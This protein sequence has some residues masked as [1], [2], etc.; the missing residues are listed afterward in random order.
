MIN[1]FECY[2]QFEHNITVEIVLDSISVY[3]GTRA[4]TML[5]E[6]PRFILP[7][8]NTHRRFSKNSASSRALSFDKVL[9][10]LKAKYYMPQLW[11]ADHQGMQTSV[12][13]SERQHSIANAIWK[14]S[15]YSAIA[16]AYLL[17]KVGVSKQYVNR[18]IEPYAY[19]K[20]LVT[21]TEWQNFFNQRD[22]YHAQY[23]IQVLARRMRQALQQSIPTTLEKGQWHLPFIA[24]ALL[25]LPLEERLLVSAARCARTSYGRN[26]GY[27]VKKDMDLSINTLLGSPP[28]MSPFEHQLCANYAEDESTSN[29]D[30][31]MQQRFIIDQ[32]VKRYGK[33]TLDK[34]LEY[35][36]YYN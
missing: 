10:K 31:W 21:S 18:I 6:F 3:S 20:V 24:G 13:V 25:E 34:Y 17:N 33:F 1:F 30:G 32:L 23:E 28:H 4:T 15:M 36:S 27:S 8:F 35:V 16:H 19:V 14:S 7:Q 26:A 5:V 9:E 11:L 2:D 12:L 29:V 22:D